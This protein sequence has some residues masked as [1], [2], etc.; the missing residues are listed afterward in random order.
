MANFHCSLRVAGS[1][2][3]ASGG[4]GN[5]V[6]PGN[7]LPEDPIGTLFE[8]EGVGLSP[9]FGFGVPESVMLLPDF[10]TGKCN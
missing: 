1:G 2:L 4:F 5:R 8:E 7:P 6:P 3:A 10:R 9:G